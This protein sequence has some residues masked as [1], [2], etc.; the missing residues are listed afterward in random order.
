MD[1]SDYTTLAELLRGIPD[2]RKK[3]GIRHSWSLVLTLIGAGMLCQQQHVRA[4]GQWVREHRH[5]LVELLEPHGGR[6]PSEATL[7]RALLGL[8]VAEL[9]ARLSD[10][11]RGRKPDN[12][13]RG[14]S[15][16]GKQVRGSGV[17]GHKVHLL[18]LARHDDSAVLAQVEVDTKTNEIGAAPDLLGT[19]E[20]MGTITTMDALLS[21]RQLAEQI[22]AKGGH[23]LMVIKEN[24]PET[25]QAIAELFRDPPWLPSERASHYWTASSC[26]KAHGRLETRVLEASDA[27][28]EWLR[29]PGVQ[30]VLRRTCRRVR[31]ARGEVSEETTYAVTSLSHTQASVEALERY[32]RGHWSIENRLH[33]VRDVTLGEDRCQAHCGQL[34]QALAVF[35]NAIILLLR[36]HGYSNLAYALRHYSAHPSLALALI[37]ATTSRL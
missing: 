32:W 31:L 13:L 26:C 36:Q 6:L 22:R 16:D 29:W 15:L 30:Q 21:Q 1:R 3:R 5:L 24:Q 12:E 25:H 4:I 8:D 28:N 34:P 18:G 33:Y 37:G 11:G 7:R 35:R 20:L 23:Y 19:Q 27:L 9:Q 17:H 10:L 2:P 14:Q